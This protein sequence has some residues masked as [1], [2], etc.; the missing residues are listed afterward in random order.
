[1]T[2]LSEFDRTLAAI[3]QGSAAQARSENF[4]VALRLLPA[5][6]RH[7][8]SAV[9]DYARFVDDL[10]DEA[11]GDR[12]ALLDAVAS[13]VRALPSGG[14]RLPVVRALGPALAPTRTGLAALTGPLVALIEAN[15]FD[16][17]RVR[18]ADFD[19]LMDYC[20]LS[21]API[22][23]L[24]LALADADDEPNVRDSDAVCA[25]LQVLEHCQDVGEDA[26]ADRIYLPATDLVASGAGPEVD[27]VDSVTAVGELFLSEHTDPRLRATIAV[28]VARSEQ[29][30]S[31]GPPL[32]RRLHGW[33]RVAVAGYLAG[34]YATAR[35]LRRAHFDV[36]AA[37]VRPSRL[38]TAGFA[39]R[40]LVRS[41]R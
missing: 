27:G 15:R 16:Q 37:P 13:D 34:G 32:V 24:V 23:R 33:A 7:G 26:R 40:T 20:A 8:L 30:L 29:L 14:A 21:A 39:V 25:A 38:G 41:G 4:P 28:Q 2:E 12:L 22:G 19:A 35:A 5:G 1:M 31:A 3:A 10:G 6:P 11:A 17:G 36:L 18:M 9:Y